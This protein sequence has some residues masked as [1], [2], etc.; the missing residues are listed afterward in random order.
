MPRDFDRWLS[1]DGCGDLR[2][3]LLGVLLLM[4][5]GVALGAGIVCMVLL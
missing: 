4:S 2:P 3:P 1:I 5:I